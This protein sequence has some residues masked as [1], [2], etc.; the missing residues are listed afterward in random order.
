MRGNSSVVE[1]L[2]PKQRVEGSIPFSRSRISF[3]ELE[4]MEVAPESPWKKLSNEFS[5]LSDLSPLQKLSDLKLKKMF[6]GLALYRGD[7]L[8]LVLMESP[9]DYQYKDKKC[10]FPIWNGVLVATDHPHHQRLKTLLPRLINHPVLPKWLYLRKSV[11]EKS[12]NKGCSQLARLI[13][14]SSPLIG[15]KKKIK[16]KKRVNKSHRRH[17]PA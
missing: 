4:Q 17:V 8:T 5:F 14:R 13:V 12:W 6:G 9:G 11:S 2:L 3:D 15:V 1:H 7:L 10:D 16:K